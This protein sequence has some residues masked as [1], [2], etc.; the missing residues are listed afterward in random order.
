M[1]HKEHQPRAIA[2]SGQSE[3]QSVRISG[4]SNQQKLC[5]RSTGGEAEAF[6]IDEAAETERRYIMS[7]HGCSVLDEGTLRDT[8]TG[9]STCADSVRMWSANHNKR[10][11]NN[12]TSAAGHD[13]CLIGSINQDD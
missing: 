3:G 12:E 11:I 8:G 2:L 5:V 4:G 6:P 9:T 1:G 10:G 13:I 7:A